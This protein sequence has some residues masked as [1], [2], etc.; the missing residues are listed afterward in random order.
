LDIERVIVRHVVGVFCCVVAKQVFVLPVF[1]DGGD[2]VGAVCLASA[3]FAPFEATDAD[4][5]WPMVAARG[6][7]AADPAPKLTR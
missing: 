1:F 2:A 7:I 3:D 6:E 4:F 5:Q